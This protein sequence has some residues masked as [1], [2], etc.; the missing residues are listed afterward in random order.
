[1]D[2]SFFICCSDV[3]V[4]ELTLIVNIY[5][6]HCSGNGVDED[7]LG[8]VTIEAPMSQPVSKKTMIEIGFYGAHQISIEPN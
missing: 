5:D 1:V 6:K 4:E 3:D 2:T 7:F 8:Q